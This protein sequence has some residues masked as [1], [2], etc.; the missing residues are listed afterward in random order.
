MTK[1]CP[2]LSPRFSPSDRYIPPPPLFFNTQVPTQSGPK[3]DYN[4]QLFSC[5]KVTHK[6]LVAEHTYKIKV[7]LLLTENAKKGFSKPVQAM[8]KHS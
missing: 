8:H 5:K 7:K 6:F 2:I 3:I 1:F 4:V